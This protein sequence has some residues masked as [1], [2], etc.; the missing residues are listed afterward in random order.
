MMEFLDRHFVPDWR[1]FWRWWS[2]QVQA[3]YA[4]IAGLFGGPAAAVA[5]GLAGVTQSNTLRIAL[6]IGVALTWFV[7]AVFPRLLK[8]TEADNGEDG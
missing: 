1:D 4:V 6:I 8:Q 2:V 5:L 7:G 3:V